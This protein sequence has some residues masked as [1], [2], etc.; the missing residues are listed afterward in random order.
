[1][2]AYIVR[3]IIQALI[4]LIIVT[5]FIFLIMRLLPGDPILMYLNQEDVQRI[6]KEEVAAIRHDLGLDRPLYVQYLDWLGDAVTGDLGNSIIHRGKIIKDIKQRLPITFHLGALALIISIIIGIPAGVIAA[7]R[8]GGWLDNVLT[9]LGNLGITIPVF[10]LGMLLMYVFGLRLDFLPMY[11][12]T[13]PVKDF[14]LSTRQIIMP[15][16][17][18]AV[19]PIAS[20]VRLTRSSML[21]VMHQDYVRTAWA[22]GLSERMVVVRHALKNGL[23]P[24]VT[25]K[26]ISVAH[27]IGGSVL[28]ET[29]FSIP[30]MGRLLVEAIFSKDYT[31]VQGVILITASVV[32]MVNLLVDLSYG[33]IDPR[34]R[35]K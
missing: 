10:W 13:S 28:I 25:L 19:P 1:M 26:G 34:I 22:K 23:I 16:F 27:I 11:G 29:V 18:L 5:V 17:C 3:R 8:R 24:V 7:I 6:T 2:T 32:L 21:E 9:T 20:A 4:V 14:W 30:G 12:Y 35:Y 33:W 31:V 15:V